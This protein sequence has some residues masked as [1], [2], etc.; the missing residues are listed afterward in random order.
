MESF[1]LSELKIKSYTSLLIVG[2]SG[3]GKTKFCMDVIK[4]RDGIFSHPHEK[5]VYMYKYDQPMFE[6]LKNTD[7]SVIFVS[8]KEDAEEELKN[9]SSTL[10]VCDDFL[11]GALD[12]EPNRKFVTSLFLEKS[13]HHKITLLFQ[14]QLLY[15]KCGRPWALNASHFVLFKNFHE[16]Q[17]QH[18]FR[19]F[20]EDAN[21]LLEAYKMCT[22]EKY[23]H[24]FISLHPSTNEDLRYRSGLILKEGLMF[25]RP[26]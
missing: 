22:K 10:L 11:T 26:S 1:K 18:F 19:N 5:V 20:G 15:A 12:S 7:P 23:G 3:S 25:F 6:E 8:S 9:S 13:H 4:H 16:S 21:F 17:I 24:F 14:T 2:K